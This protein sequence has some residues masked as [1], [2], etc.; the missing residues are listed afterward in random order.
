VYTTG[1]EPMP[2][3]EYVRLDM[4]S[5]LTG[6]PDSIKHTWGYIVAGVVVGLVVLV[7][8]AAVFYL[9]WKHR[10]GYVELADKENVS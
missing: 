1:V 2:S 9:R 8:F 6:S 4:H 10:K 7:G 3:S 5:M